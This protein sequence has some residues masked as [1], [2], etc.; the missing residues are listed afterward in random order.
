MQSDMQNGSSPAL[1]ELRK[2]LSDGLARIR[3]NKTDLAKRAGLGRTT[4]QEAFRSG[5]PVP[6]A[7]TVAALARALKLP[8]EELME[9]RRLAAAEPSSGAVDASGPGRP[10]DEWDPHSL[11]V[12]PVGRIDGVAPGPW[13]LPGYVSREHDRFLQAAV[14]DAAKG[15]SRMVVLVGTSSTG[16]TRA[17]WEAVQ[18]LASAG[19]RLWH[20]FDPT[21]AEAAIEDLHR[22]RPRTVVWLNEAQHYLGDP[23][24][25]ERI[26]AAAHT[27]LIQPERAPILVLATLW[28]EY[29]DQ[30]TALAA[31]GQPDPHSRVRELLAGRMVSIPDSFD[32][33]ALAAATV[34]AENG[35]RQ[36][37]DA[38]T[39]TGDHGR[40]TQDLAG[41]PALVHRYQ[42]STPAARA[43]LE[44]AMDA[45]RFGI[46]PVLPQTFLTDAAID[47]LTDTEL[48]RLTPDWSEAAFAELARM[49]H[50]RQ[51]PLR[52]T[53]LRRQG[54]PPK[55]P[56]PVTTPH[57]TAGPTFRLADY[58]EQHGRTNRRSLCPPASFWH[59]HTHLTHPGDLI[60]LT[61]AASERYRLQWA[62]HLCRQAADADVEGALGHLAVIRHK[63]GDREGSELLY[64]QAADAGDSHAMAVLAV[65]REGDGDREKAEAFARRA[66]D[67]GNLDGL[68]SLA[69]IRERNG[70]KESAF[71]L[72]EEAEGIRE[73][74]GAEWVLIKDPEAEFRQAV[75]AGDLSELFHW[76]A[77]RETTGDTEG[78]ETLYRQAAAT[79]HAEA[80]LRLAEMREKAGDR[81]DA[82]AL[83][84]K[85][86]SAGKGYAVLRLAVNR[87]KAG[88]R[89]GAEAVARR[90]AHIDATQALRG[91][92][93]MREKAGDRES[94]EALARQA[95]HT[96][97][98]YAF[99]SLAHIRHEAGDPEGVESIYQQAADA[100]DPDVLFD[101]GLWREKA[102][103]VE[104]AETLYQQ[105][106]GTGHGRALARLAEMRERA[107][108]V[109]AAEALALQAANAGA[110]DV[111]RA[112]KRWPYGL[113]PDG[114]PTPPWL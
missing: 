88:D 48:D 101:W 112:S 82:E 6:S 32:A 90:A 36:L 38:L 81:M 106:A 59:A 62:Y 91:L 70:D 44:A 8:P 33:H 76:A 11:E 20:P 15:R 10:I 57:P 56:S 104:G 87:E 63:V 3:L 74:V 64:R 9:L 54:R 65:M 94:A 107:G 71:T 43:V 18:S 60:R 73:G 85:A 31:P 99:H 16:K 110:A 45:R 2:R 77:W 47:Y 4:V 49:V 109:E 37:A 69:G 35:D 78:A 19:W 42:H 97:K 84:L 92:A 89:E 40:V 26:A 41:G 5:G 108:D 51:A 98:F 23:Q 86:V 61:K 79:G 52:R 83:A 14:E 58:L 113:D 50:G 7:E 1:T 39:R 46:G 105:A 29:A 53:A 55:G 17:C 100:G 93:E 68:Y 12:H 96:G 103:D 72:A 27:L 21:R 28:P 34:L 24:A 22:V 114:T 66:A 30:Y 67:A 25:G 75:D 13:L 111:L 80:M 95:A 102:E